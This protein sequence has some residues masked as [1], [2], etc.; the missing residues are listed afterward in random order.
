[1]PPSV[2]INRIVRVLNIPA[3]KHIAFF[4][5]IVLAIWEGVVLHQIGASITDWR[6]CFIETSFNGSVQSRTYV[7]REIVETL[8]KCIQRLVGWA[9][10]IG[11]W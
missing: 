11:S 6:G 4:V 1:M 5:L 2:V 10:S 8:Q 3:A 7:W 9:A